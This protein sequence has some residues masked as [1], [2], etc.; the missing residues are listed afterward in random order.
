MIINPYSV[1][2]AHTFKNLY[3]SRPSS[4]PLSSSCSSPPII[5]STTI[6]ITVIPI[7]IH[8]HPSHFPR[9]FPVSAIA[10]PGTRQLPGQ[11]YPTYAASDRQQEA[12][13]RQVAALCQSQSVSQHPISRAHDVRVL[14]AE[15]SGLPRAVM[16]YAQNRSGF[17]ERW[18]CLKTLDESEIREVDIYDMIGMVSTQPT[19]MSMAVRP[20]IRV[21][22]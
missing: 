14:K 18:G 20:R 5:I 16:G 21:G 6:V 11:S 19:M 12:G 9:P 2:P 22:G 4:S 8:P 1:L 10:L 7:H 17:S 3:R 13:S 15:A